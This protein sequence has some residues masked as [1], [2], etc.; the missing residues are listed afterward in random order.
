MLSTVNKIGDS[1]ENSAVCCVFD[2]NSGRKEIIYSIA[3]QDAKYAIRRPNSGLYHYFCTE[4]EELLPYPRLTVDQTDNIIVVGPPGCGKSW[5]SRD[6]A[7]AYHYCYPTRRIY[8]I[9]AKQTDKAFDPHSFITRIHPQDVDRHALLNDDDSEEEDDDDDDSQA[10]EEPK[11]K[12]RKLS[13]RVF[14]PIEHFKDSLYIFDDIVTISPEKTKKLVKDF[15]NMLSKLGRASNVALIFCT[16]NMLQYNQSRDEINELTKYVFFPAR[17]KKHTYN[18]FKNYL[19]LE[20]EAIEL[21][22]ASDQNR[23]KMVNITAPVT[24][25]TSKECFILD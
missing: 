23:W 2:R 4:S 24:V 7:F 13:K 8:L 22:L 14:K 20:K 17:M 9:S 15:K 21:L 16:Q 10:A 18:Y 19:H 6:F 5:F 1:P 12:R 25:V 3:Q 11:K